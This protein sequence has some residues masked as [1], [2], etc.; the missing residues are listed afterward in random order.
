MPNSEI[1]SIHR[2]AKHEEKDSKYSNIRSTVQLHK[3]CRHLRLRGWGPW[4]WVIIFGCLAGNGMHGCSKNIGQKCERK[5]PLYY[6]NI[7]WHA[8]LTDF[9]ES[10]C[11]AMCLTVGDA[12]RHC[13]KLAIFTKMWTEL[14]DFQEHICIKCNVWTIFAKTKFRIFRANWKRHSH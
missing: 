11:K 6:G 2:V 14:R 1:T 4:C 7:S 8:I 13:E 9:C 5:R 3:S 12:K 10:L